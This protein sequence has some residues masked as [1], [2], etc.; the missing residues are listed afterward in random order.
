MDEDKMVDI[1]F[2]CNLKLSPYQ[3]KVF[4]G[5]IAQLY[6]ITEGYCTCIDKFEYHEESFIRDMH[7]QLNQMD[8]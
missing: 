3:F 2:S 5:I 7:E 8:F 6:N 4:R 1:N